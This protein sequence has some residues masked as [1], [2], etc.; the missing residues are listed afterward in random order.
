MLK[1]TD[2]SS[3]LKTGDL[4]FG[5]LQSCPI[6][7]LHSKGG[8]VGTQQGCIASGLKPASLRLALMGKPSWCLLAACGSPRAWTPARQLHL[9]APSSAQPS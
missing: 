3:A 1:R 9:P 7:L 8:P 4:N 2:V 5:P 6:P